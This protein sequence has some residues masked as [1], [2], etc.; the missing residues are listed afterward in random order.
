MNKPK[1]HEVLK[2][3]LPDKFTN[4]ANG[5]LLEKDIATAMGM[6]RQGVNLWFQKDQIPLDKINR[7]MSIKGNTLV[8]EDLAPF[9]YALLLFLALIGKF[10]VKRTK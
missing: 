4:Q 1:L 5:R 3:H 6:S 10:Q 7:L 2:E 9:C 8:L